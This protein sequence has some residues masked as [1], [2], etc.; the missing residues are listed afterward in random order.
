MNNIPELNTLN[1]MSFTLVNNVQLI[2]GLTNQH[3]SLLTS[4]GIVDLF[5]PVEVVK[6]LNNNI[7]TNLP[8]HA[9]KIP[10]QQRATTAT[11]DANTLFSL[12]YIYL[13]HC[14]YATP[15]TP[16]LHIKVD[17]I[18]SF[19]DYALENDEHLTLLYELELELNNNQV[20]NHDSTRAAMPIT[21][22]KPNNTG[23]SN[24]I[25]KQGCTSNR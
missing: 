2:G 12:Y 18:V 6:I 25:I 17:K 19:F 9:F 10:P 24:I 15:N 4:D 11:T 23:F 5:Y 16:V 7:K 8:T 20:I 14:D 1:F 22:L 21:P 13:H 3:M